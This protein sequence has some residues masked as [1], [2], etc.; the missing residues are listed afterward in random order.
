VSYYF[1]KILDK[2]FDQAI[3]DVTEALK[4]E[5]F[6]VLTQIDVSTT[7]KNKLDVDFHRYHILGACNPTYAHKALTEENKVGTMLPCNVIV[8]QLDDGK[9]EVAAVDP[10]ASMSGINNPALE[11]IAREVQGKLK[12]VIESLG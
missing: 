4:G 11:G 6:G 10:I 7:L 8:Q 9:V 2:D 5:G 3:A 1:A 12:K